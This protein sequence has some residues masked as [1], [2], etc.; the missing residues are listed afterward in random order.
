M[1]KLTKLLD[2]HCGNNF[3]CGLKPMAV[4][5]Y[6]NPCYWYR[7]F[8]SKL[9]KAHEKSKTGFVLVRWLWGSLDKIPG[10]R[11]SGPVVPDLAAK[12]TSRRFLQKNRLKTIQL[13]AEGWMLEKKHVHMYI[14]IYVYIQYTCI[15][16]LLSFK[17]HFKISVGN[18]HFFAE[19]V[20]EHDAI[21]PKSRKKGD[22]MVAARHPTGCMGRGSRLWGGLPKWPVGVW[23]P[24]ISCWSL[25]QLREIWWN[26]M[27]Y[28]DGDR[29][30]GRMGMGIWGWGWNILT[31]QKAAIMITTYNEHTCF[32]KLTTQPP[33][34]FGGVQLKSFPLPPPGRHF[35]LRGC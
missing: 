3:K 35:E 5:C 28:W 11:N 12:Q 26:M 4:A 18:C 17:W 27:I 8:F 16:I 20:A 22:K 14:Y 2:P 6:R 23:Q 9:Q 7:S 10:C 33:F 32:G 15:N 31:L 21:W 1:W 24:K 19:E 30:G 13:L 34:F 25:C 29:D